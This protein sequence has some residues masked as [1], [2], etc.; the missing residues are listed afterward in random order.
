MK[1]EIKVGIF[2]V[3]A[4]LSLFILSIQVNSFSNF[5]KKG[6]TLYS[7]INDTT[8][9]DINSKIKMRGVTVGFL[10][11]KEL[12]YNG[13]RLT[14]FINEGILIPLNSKISITQDSM[15]GG[16]YL[17]IVPS[18]SVHFLKD[19]D[20]ITDYITV[21]TFDQAVDSI[22][23]AAQEFKIFMHRL[24]DTIDDNASK[25][26]KLSIANLQNAT[27]SLK[28]ILKENRMNIKDSISGIK[29]AVDTVNSKLPKIL[30]QTDELTYEFSKV[31]KTINKDLPNIM[32][33]IDSLTKR[34]DDTGKHINKKLPTLLT[35]FE[36]I[37]DNV[38]TILE[39]NRKPLNV[40]LKSAGGFFGSGKDTF[41]KLDDYFAKLMKST[42]E[43]DIST[44]YMTNDGYM[45][46]YANVNYIPVP[47]KYY[48]FSVISQ[49]DYSDANNFGKLHEK[50]KTLISAQLGK[51]Y[52]NL[53]LRG[54][55]L[56]STGGI[57]F[58]YY[59]AQDKLKMSAE[60]FD[61][62]AVNDIRGSNA[63]ANI[64]FRYTIRKHLN[65]YLGY[66]NFLN[67]D[68]ANL[69]LGF[70]VMF[71]D[72]DLKSLLGSAGTSFLK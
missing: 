22:N 38:T 9:L 28:V 4:L 26:L 13:V 29:V 64:N 30:N 65:F 24:N 59:F 37:E 58:D 61:F 7:I 67:R 35:K 6:Y 36:K 31:G 57:G 32:V 71:N 5:N 8:G 2:V 10:E 43:V 33:Q 53:L 69:Y 39:E 41:K 16:K 1:L 40:A 34:F 55:I 17:K 50:Q 25:S 21:A 66:D 60:L 18:N 19:N 23:E 15:L 72:D 27:D 54:G 68:I 42:L 45:K 12:K 3:L 62:N 48:M 20:S 11:Y 46:T 14:L 52:D 47:T 70:G 63:H 51:R 49:N 44:R 56:E